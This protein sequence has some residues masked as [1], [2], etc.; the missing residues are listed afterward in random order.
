ML[1]L[2][3]TVTHERHRE[4]IRD[5]LPNGHGP[6]HVRPG[7]HLRCVRLV[8]VAAARPYPNRGGRDVRWPERCPG[9]VR[10]LSSGR[11]HVARC[12]VR[13]D[14]APIELPTLRIIA[15]HLTSHVVT[16]ECCGAIPTVW[17]E[18]NDGRES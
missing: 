16:A 18:R 15:R 13:G 17:L 14:C 7:H 4:A 11:V 10:N 6:T 2:P 9:S 3:W 1:L 12:G 8:H 5:R